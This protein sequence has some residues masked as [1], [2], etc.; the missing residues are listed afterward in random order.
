MSLATKAKARKAASPQHIASKDLAKTQEIELG[1][2]QAPKPLK[3]GGFGRSQSRGRINRAG[4][5]RARVYHPA[6]YHDLGGEI[7]TATVDEADAITLMGEDDN[8]VKVEWE[9]EGNVLLLM[10]APSDADIERIKVTLTN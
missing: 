8:L 4:T 2:F 7:I 5:V 1:F 6:D 10:W 9:L 3:D